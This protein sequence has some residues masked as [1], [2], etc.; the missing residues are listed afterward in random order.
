MRLCAG[1]AVPQL[2]F[3]TSYWHCL[4]PIL[5]AGLMLQF[6]L[7]SLHLIGGLVGYFMCKAAKYDEVG[8]SPA[9]PMR[10]VPLCFAQHLPRG[11]RCA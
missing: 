11:T 9:L 8:Q 4:Q 7:I 3:Y 5:E 6:P 10:L 2:P 1:D